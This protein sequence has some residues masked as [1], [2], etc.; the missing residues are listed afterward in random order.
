MLAARGVGIVS[1]TRALG[2]VVV[3]AIV[4]I[5]LGLI[6]N[7]YAAP[8]GH[9]GASGGHGD[10][11]HGETLFRQGACPTCHTIQGMSNGTIGPELT[12]IATVGNSRKAGTTAEAYIKESIETPNAFVAPGFTAPSAMPGGQAQGKNL[13]DLVA[14]LLTKN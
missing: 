5:P 2:S 9:E 4:V 14:F 3:V 8:E 10:A 1:T 12:H 6:A 7:Q 13:D 11:A